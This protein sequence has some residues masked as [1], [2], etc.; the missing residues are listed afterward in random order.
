[1]VLTEILK[2]Y[3]ERIKATNDL[4]VS[5]NKFKR[6]LFEKNKKV[7]HLWERRNWEIEK[8]LK[9][10]LEDEEL[11]KSMAAFNL[12]VKTGRNKKFEDIALEIANI[13]EYKTAPNVATKKEIIANEL[14]KREIINFSAEDVMRIKGKADWELNKKQH[15]L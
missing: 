9:E 14:F 15:T 12:E 2:E 5:E 1:M 11:Q 7:R 4:F 8:Y 10:L 13:E 3:V 6:F